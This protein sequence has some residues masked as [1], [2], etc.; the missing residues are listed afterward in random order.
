LVAFGGSFA[1]IQGALPSR[2]DVP[3][4]LLM[5]VFFFSFGLFAILRPDKLR[6]A[7]DNFGNAWKQGSWHPYRFMPYHP[8]GTSLPQRRM[9]SLKAWAR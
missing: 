7:M 4:V 3:A 1:D 8:E 2:G 9:S 5:A 6:N